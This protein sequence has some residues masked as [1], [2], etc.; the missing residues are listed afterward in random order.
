MPSPN[1]TL[2]QGRQW[3]TGFGATQD[4][5]LAHLKAPV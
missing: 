2:D 1:F 5:A 4:E 3:G